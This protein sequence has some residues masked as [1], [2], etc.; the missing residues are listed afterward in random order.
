MKFLSPTTCLLVP[1]L[2]LGVL[3]TVSLTAGGSGVGPDDRYGVGSSVIRYNVRAQS[4]TSPW[5]SGGG[6]ITVRDSAQQAA[7]T[8]HVRFQ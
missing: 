7:A 1:L 4:P 2:A 8:H 6:N 3:P 5:P